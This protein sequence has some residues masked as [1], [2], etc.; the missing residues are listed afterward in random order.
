MGA[1]M[2]RSL[3]DFLGEAVRL[4]CTAT[5]Y[6]ALD[7]EIGKCGSHFLPTDYHV[8]RTIHSRDETS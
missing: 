4:G 1:A 2:Q 3:L 5:I 8:V 6:V 7:P